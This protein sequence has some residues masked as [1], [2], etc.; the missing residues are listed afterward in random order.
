MRTQCRTSAG[1]DTPAAWAAEP[2]QAAAA[3]LSLLRPVLGSSR[4]WHAQYASGQ[5][6][7]LPT[8][9]AIRKSL[10]RLAGETAEG[11]RVIVYLAT[12][13]VR[14]AAGKAH[15]ATDDAMI[16][17]Q[18]GTQ[19]RPIENALPLS[20]LA[21]SICKLSAAEVFV[22][23]DLCAVDAPIGEAEL[24]AVFGASAKRCVLAW[25]A[26]RQEYW[27]PEGRITRLAGR[28]VDALRGAADADADGRVGHAELIAYLETGNPGPNPVAASVHVTAVGK[29]LEWQHALR[30]AQLDALAVRLASVVT[31]TLE[32]QGRGGDRL[33]VQ[34]PVA[35][36]GGGLVTPHAKILARRLAASLAER[37]LR[38]EC[39]PPDA[40]PLTVSG[41]L[42]LHAQPDRLVVD[43]E[44]RSRDRRLVAIRDTA[45]A[46]GDWADLVLPTARFV[47]T[48]SRSAAS[49]DGLRSARVEGIDPPAPVA[50]SARH[51]HFTAYDGLPASFRFELT[52][53]AGEQATA[54]RPVEVGGD[55]YLPVEKGRCLRILAQRQSPAPCAML[56]LIDGGNVLSSEGLSEDAR[57][58]APE[59]H[60]ARLHYFILDQS[61]EYAIGHWITLG[62]KRKAGPAVARRLVVA[63]GPDAVGYRQ[64]GAELGE[65]RILLYA[66]RSASA[67]ER[68]A[69][70]E[71]LG[72]A[73]GAA[74][75]LPMNFVRWRADDSAP[76]ARL[77]Y[78]YRQPDCI[79]GEASQ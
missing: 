36:T 26:G 75:D 63:D 29:Q 32:S 24:P 60:L 77:V 12:A 21:E 23:L 25:S 62:E 44:L 34:E 71:G 79:P 42:E 52:D 51:P 46:T 17:P 41:R 69:L 64:P 5:P 74:S 30:P 31:R 3:T 47:S 55:C 67:G 9:E 66:A 49:F 13:V 53:A 70:A 78:R 38:V 4:G 20:D 37:G 68:S 65:I 43:L 15:L 1:R 28:L 35:A 16:G 56:V 76:H 50:A 73:A 11:D 72:M 33:A 39:G 40:A 8:G 58:A 10:Q 22:V 45:L 6:L 48:P 19:G 61:Q 27:E 59:E 54:I 14:D 2:A 57:F 18:R 7:E